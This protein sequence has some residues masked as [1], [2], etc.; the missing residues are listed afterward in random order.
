MLGSTDED[1]L[2]LIRRR[3]IVPTP[4]AVGLVTRRLLTRHRTT[5]PTLA[6]ERAA[7]EYTRPPDPEVAEVSLSEVDPVQRVRDR[8]LK[9]LQEGRDL[10]EAVLV[11][12]ED[13]A[14][15]VYQLGLLARIQGRDTTLGLELA[16][17]VWLRLAVRQAQPDELRDL[18]TGEALELLV[19]RGVLARVVGA[20]LHPQLEVAR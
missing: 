3:A 4:A 5:R 9:A 2:D 17:G 20:G 11:D 19:E 15:A 16:P 18:Q 13:F 7:F 8:L 14:D 12:A 6:S 1:M 10:T